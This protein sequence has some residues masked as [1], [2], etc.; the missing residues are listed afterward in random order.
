[1]LSLTL[2]F[3]LLFLL[4]IFRI[5]NGLLVTTFFDPDEYWQSL[6]IAHKSVFGYGGVTWEW[7]PNTAL[8]SFLHPGLFALLYKV[9]QLTS[10]DYPIVVVRLYIRPRE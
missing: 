8:R 5:L 7:S 4:I 2:F 6:E 1:V 10:L 3:R 9:L